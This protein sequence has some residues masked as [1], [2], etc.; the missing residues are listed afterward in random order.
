MVRNDCGR[1]RSNKICAKLM[2]GHASASRHCIGTG[3][4]G[5]GTG[6]IPSSKSF[7]ISPSSTGDGDCGSS[8]IRTSTSAYDALATCAGSSSNAGA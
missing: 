3:H 2:I 7:I 1:S 5:A 6:S 4:C 8:D